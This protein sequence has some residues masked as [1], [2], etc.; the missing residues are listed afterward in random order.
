MCGDEH[1]P[2]GKEHRNVC[3][4]EHKGNKHGQS[5]GQPISNQKFEDIIHIIF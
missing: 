2:A 5:Y 1:L 3:G 4:D